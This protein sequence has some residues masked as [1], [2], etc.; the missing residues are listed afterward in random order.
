MGQDGRERPPF[1]WG[2]RYDLMGLV[3]GVLIGVALSVVGMV[4]WLAL[5]FAFAAANLSAFAFR[6]RARRRPD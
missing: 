4:V 1:V 5:T 2:D 3:V 6:R